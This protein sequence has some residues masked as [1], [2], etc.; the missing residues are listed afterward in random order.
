VLLAKLEITPQKPVR[1][2]REQDPEEV[3][4]WKDEKF[5]EILVDAKNSGA[6]VFFLD[7]TG[8]RLDDQVGRT[9][10]QCGE[11]PVV[12]CTGK[13][14][15]TNGIIA[16]SLTGAFWYEEFGGNLNSERFCELLDQFMKTRRKKVV[17]ITDRHPTHTSKATTE[18]INNMGHRL[19]VHFLPSYSPELNPVE[20]V[21][22]FVKKTGPR[23]KLP[24]DKIHL[25]EIVQRSLGSLKGAFGK[26]KRFFKHK[27]L[28]YI[29]L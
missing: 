27:E 20:Y 3:K 6:E 11:T 4:E 14:G 12:K 26:I 24:R 7:E 1:Q 17:L 13:R 29:H 19:T 22:H 18:H 16:M 8:F 21:N 9:W 28:D 5:P 10:G 25:S 23:K 2:A 15:R